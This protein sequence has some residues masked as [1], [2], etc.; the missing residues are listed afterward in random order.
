MAAADLLS[1]LALM[2]WCG[3]NLVSTLAVAVYRRGLPQPE[4]PGV[5]PN[6][7]VILPVKSAAN[8]DRFLPLLRAQK[9]RSFR[10]VA[11]VESSDDP[12]FAVLSAAERE[13]RPSIE[14]VVAGPAVNAG[15]KVWNQLAALERLAPDDE[16]VAFIDADTAPTPLWLPRLVA[17]IVNAKRPVATGYRWMFPADGRLSSACLAAANASIASLPRGVLPMPL[18]WGGSVAMRRTTLEAIDLKQAWR[19]AIS[20]D[21]QIAEALRRHGLVAHAPRQGLLLTRV[22]CSWREFLAFG[23]RQYRFVYL[24]QPKNWAAA[25]LTLWA[26]PLCIAL[27]APAL[28]AGSALAW[29]ALALV[30]VLGEAR[31]R[32]RRSLQRALWPEVG[33]PDDERCWRAERWLRPV[34]HFLHALSAAGAPL[35]RRIEWAG[36]RYFVRGPQDVVIEGSE[37]CALNGSIP[38]GRSPQ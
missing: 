17:V 10:V 5:E 21:S 36:I 18:V 11:A 37:D 12:A 2:V 25:A 19:G 33:G 29:A 15:Q 7:A 27:A 38:R 31:V 1:D 22:S 28:I 24:H 35:T 34:W 20:D 6:V 30:L 32:L 23:V 8:L 14:T 9:Y 3:Q 16:I 26:P 13:P 4:V